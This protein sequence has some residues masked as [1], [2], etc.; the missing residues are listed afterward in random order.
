MAELN[1]NLTPKHVGDA[2]YNISYNGKNNTPLNVNMAGH[3][4]Y[5]DNLFYVHKSIEDTFMCICFIIASFGFVGN[6]ATIAKIVHDLNLHTPTFTAI[7][8]LA[9]ADVLSIVNLNFIIVTNNEKF[10]ETWII[11]MRSFFYY[12]FYWSSSGHVLLLSIVRYL[13]TVHPLQSRRYLTVA[14]IA[15]FSLVV[16]LI[17][18]LFG[19]IKTYLFYIHVN[20]GTNV[21]VLVNGIAYTI[22]LLSVCSVTILLHVWKIKAIQ[23]S[24]SITRHTRKRMNLVVTGIIIVFAL[25]QIF[26]IAGVFYTY[27]CKVSEDCKLT[28][29]NVFTFGGIL[30]G[31]ISYSVNPYLFFFLSIFLSRYDK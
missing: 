20:N 30:T 27:M 29:F 22:A 19:V 11:L 12:M 8:C 6:L 18:F 26:T 7:G 28:V 17:S 5:V 23:T 10:A 2:E 4:Y 13:L 21:L 31:C 9:M 1:F 16:W 15:L 24:P 25:Y 14:L 3:P